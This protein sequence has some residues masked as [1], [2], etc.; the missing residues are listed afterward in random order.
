MKRSE[1]L[2]DAEENRVA[3]DACVSVSKGHSAFCFA[4]EERRK[5]GVKG[6][7]TLKSEQDGFQESQRR[8]WPF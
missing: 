5:T 4:V 7:R 8:H 6:V 2:Q 1:Q 3:A